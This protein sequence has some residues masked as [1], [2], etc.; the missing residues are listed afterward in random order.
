MRDSTKPE[1]GSAWLFRVLWQPHRVRRDG[2]P[3]MVA[4]LVQAGREHARARANL[5]ALVKREHAAGASLRQLAELSG[6]SKSTVH[7]IIERSV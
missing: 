4:E 1:D 3:P 6:L 5:E 7:R 2:P